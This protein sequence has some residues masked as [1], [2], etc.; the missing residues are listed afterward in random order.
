MLAVLVLSF[1]C[2]L[3]KSHLTCNTFILASNLGDISFDL[4]FF[5]P[6][7][8]FLM[9]GSSLSIP[10]FSPSISVEDDETE[11]IRFT[12]SSDSFNAMLRLS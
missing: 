1:H 4:I 3:S 2:L 10:L 9:A 11:L 5:I 6:S 7:K 12:A 8:S